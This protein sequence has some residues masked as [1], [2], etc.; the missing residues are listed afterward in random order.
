MC[1]RA[2]QLVDDLVQV[3][4]AAGHRLA[5]DRHDLVAAPDAG[6]VA[7]RPGDGRDHDDLRR[8]GPRPAMPIPPNSPLRSSSS[9]CVVLRFQEL[10]MRVE[11]LDHPVE[12]R[13]GQVG[14]VGRSWVD[15]VLVHDLQHI[16]HVG[17]RAAQVPIGPEAEQR[18][19]GQ[20]QAGQRRRRARRRGRAMRIP[21]AH[22]SNCVHRRGLCKWDRLQIRPGARR[23]L[24]RRFPRSAPV[25]AETLRFAEFMRPGP[26]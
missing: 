22:G 25:L 2:P 20:R 9:S 10:R 17:G 24:C 13:V 21:F 26:L 16:A 1:G 3:G 19:Q 18:G 8:R 7:R 6:A 5:V 4:A 12:R 23:R 11:R 15:V 14:V